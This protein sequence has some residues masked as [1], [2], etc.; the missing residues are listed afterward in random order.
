MPPDELLSAA[1]RGVTVDL[2]LS[3]DSDH[4]VT[5]HARH[6]LMPQPLVRGVR[7]HLQPPPFCHTKLFVIDRQY[8]QLGSANLDMRSLRLNFEMMFETYDPGFAEAMARHADTLIERATTLHL[9]ALR[10]RPL[11]PRLR[12]AICWLA[13]PYL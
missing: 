6:K 5:W 10:R 9:D 13:S 2:V 7:V 1:L 3:R 11:L 8:L 4:R 12:D